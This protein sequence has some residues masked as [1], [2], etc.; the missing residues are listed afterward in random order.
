MAYLNSKQYLN[1]SIQ[2]T[3]FPTY[4]LYGLL[5]LMGILFC[6]SNSRFSFQLSRC[7]CLIFSV[8]ISSSICSLD[9]NVLQI[10]S[11]PSPSTV[12]VI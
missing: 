3:L 6:D 5:E 12:T 8:G 1:D 7:H 2:C 9:I 4:D 10:S 11:L